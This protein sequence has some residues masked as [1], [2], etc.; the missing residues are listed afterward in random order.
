MVKQLSI[1]GMACCLK[2]TVLENIKTLHPNIK[3]DSNDL[4]DCPKDINILTSY[5]DLVLF[6]SLVISKINTATVETIYDRSFLSNYVY[7]AI[8]TLMKSHT[9]WTFEKKTEMLE[10][11]VEKYIKHVRINKDFKFLIFLTSSKNNEKQLDLM[12]RRANGIDSMSE[13]YIDLQRVAWTRFCECDS[14]MFIRVDV[15]LLG[16]LDRMR[17]NLT[18]IVLFHYNDM[19]QQS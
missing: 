6:N 17:D 10:A 1:E 9:K 13:E 3:M 4:P 7:G 12:K 16:N 11:Y 5:L 8:N 19:L 2:S 14:K 15:D 18:N